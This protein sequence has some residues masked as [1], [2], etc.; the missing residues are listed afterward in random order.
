MC[1]KIGMLAYSRDL[2][3]PYQSIIPYACGIHSAGLRNLFRAHAEYEVDTRKDCGRCGIPE[4][5]DTLCDLDR[6]C[7]TPR[8]GSQGYF[9]SHC[10][11]C[12]FLKKVDS[13]NVTLLLIL[14]YVDFLAFSPVRG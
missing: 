4:K 10:T 8:S 13:V 12:G 14:L 9:A 1:T 2:G 11:Q 3:R 7:P 6:G 5:V